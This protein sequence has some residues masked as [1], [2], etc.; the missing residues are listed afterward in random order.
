MQLSINM[1]RLDVACHGMTMQTA[2][3][4]HI[5][6]CCKEPIKR[7][8]SRKESVP[9]AIYSLDGKAEYEISALCEHCFDEIT[10]R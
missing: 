3:Q 9:G 2:M 7:V 4:A 6:I 8:G 10:E 1:Q 5:C